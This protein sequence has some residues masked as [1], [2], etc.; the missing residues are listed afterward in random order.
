MER[1]CAMTNP[2]NYDSTRVVHVLL[3]LR[4]GGLW[5]W[6]TMTRLGDK[7]IVERVAIAARQVRS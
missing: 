2:N 1:F 3:L 4:T 7:Y 6:P 5:G